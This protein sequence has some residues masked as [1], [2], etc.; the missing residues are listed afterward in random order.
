MRFRVTSRQSHHATKMALFAAFSLSWAGAPLRCGSPRMAASDHP[1]IIEESHLWVVACKP[2][3]I[4]VHDG[5]DSLLRQLKPLVGELLPVH[6]LDRETSGV[7]LL[8]K[9]S[10]AAAELQASLAS[11]ECVKRYRGVVNGVVKGN[12]RREGCW[13]KALTPKAEGRKNPQGKSADRVPA[14][15]AYR[16]VSP[17]ESRFLS[18]MDF[19]LGSGRTHQ[20]RKHCAMSGHHLLGDTR[21]GPL[22]H[23]KK[24]ESRYAFD[25][26]A[27]HAASLRVRLDGQL[28]DFGTPPPAAWAPLLEPFGELP[29]AGEGDMGFRQLVSKGRAAPAPRGAAKGAAP[30]PGPP[31][32]S[33]Q[34]DEAME[35][36]MEDGELQTRSP[37]EVARAFERFAAL[38]ASKAMEKGARPGAD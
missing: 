36:A 34:M 30:A 32:S 7:I 38:K 2:P 27:L 16:V 15:T 37:E 24:I 28:R 12:A 13:T 26:M 17:P 25:G 33:R 19:E 23:A 8:A 4:A 20:I 11:D 1:L 22:A 6:R 21:Y 18:V 3:G 9:S 29:E 35:E 10:E 31:L 14:S 5:K